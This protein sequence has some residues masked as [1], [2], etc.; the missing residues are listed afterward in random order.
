[1][2]AVTDAV[3]TRVRGSTAYG[4]GY[5]YAVCTAPLDLVKL[6]LSL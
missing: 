3:A 2:E 5:K 4:V 1:M 6:R